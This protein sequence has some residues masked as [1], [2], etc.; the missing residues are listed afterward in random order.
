MN[1]SRGRS[2]SPGGRGA[3]GWNTAWPPIG[4]SPTASAAAATTTTTTAAAAA[5][6]AGALARRQVVEEVDQHSQAAVVAAVEAE[7]QAGQVGDRGL[8]L[9]DRQGAAQAVVAAGP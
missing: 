5:G 3:A 6:A 1:A 2:R 9:L 8:V 7:D 4:Y